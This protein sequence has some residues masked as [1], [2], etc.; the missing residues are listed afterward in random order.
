MATKKPTRL[1]TTATQAP[2]SKEAVVADIRAIGDAQRE[3]QR[4]TADLNDKVAALQQQY[5][6]DAAPFN[7]RIETL[8]AGVQ[9]WC[10]ANREELTNGDKTKTVD[11]VTGMVKWRIKPPSVSVR[12]AEAVVALLKRSGLQRF[13]R[14]KEEVNKEAI[15][16]EQDAARGIAGLA[17]VSGVEEFVIE[18]HDQ[19][20]DAA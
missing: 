19:Q 2:Q 14:T 10:E 9:T 7:E 15:L 3:V 20:L 11:F 8:Q 1:K 18:P 6:A 5:A 13:V 16:N 4:L 12:G 17:I